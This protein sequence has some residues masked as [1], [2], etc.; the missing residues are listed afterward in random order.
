MKTHPHTT[1]A[2][3]PLLQL[4]SSLSLGIV[5]STYQSLGLLTLGVL[6]VT[7]ALIALLSGLKHRRMIAGVS[8]LAAFFCAG[9]TLAL[10]E[11]RQDQAS[12]LKPWLVDHEGETCV[13]TG[14]LDGPP[15]FARGR[16]YLTLRVE[17]LSTAAAEV[18]SSGLVALMAPMRS[19]AIEQEYLNLQLH[20]GTRL[21]VRTLLNHADQYRNPGVSTLTEYLDR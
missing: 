18:R 6:S 8:L 21:R 19:S 3:Y 13:L 12:L 15:E 7:S 11:Q 1:F 17:G 16:L 10:L 4:A 20:Y 2:Q 14:V 9:G 5:A